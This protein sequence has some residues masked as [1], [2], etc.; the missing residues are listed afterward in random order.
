MAEFRCRLAT[1]SGEVVER[2]FTA[3]DE[4]ELRRELERQEFLVLGMQRRSALISA[5]SD[6]FSRRRRKLN[7]NEFLYFNQEFAALVRAGLPIVESLGMLLERRKNL[8]FRSA[9]EDIRDR[10]RSGESLSEAFGAHEMFPPLYASTL[11]SGERSGEIATVLD[12]YV[13][14]MKIITGVRSK[15]RAALTYPAVLVALS[16]GLVAML[17]T[18]VLPKFE[19]LFRDFGAELPLITRSVL[20]LST[21][22]RDNWW[23]LLLSLVGAVVGLA[24]WRRTPAGRR[25]LER[26][27]YRMPFAGS[28]SS[29]FVV[30]RFARTLSTLIAG[31]IPLV[32]CLEIVSRAVGVGIFRDAI[33]GVALKIREGAA[34]W[35]AIEETRL[36]PDLLVEMVKVGESSGSLAEML[37]HVADFTDQEIERDLQ[38]MMSLIEPLLLIALAL[39]VG[40]LLLAIYYPLLIIYANTS[41]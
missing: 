34:L 23:L 19:G 13:S 33:S 2:D 27:M 8:A 37:E 9:L 17:L 24:V 5:A 1:P 11:A 28:I 3:G 26:A 36:F 16:L 39:I 29:K 12:R 18:Y 41:I 7:L 30:T 35:S 22:I 40:F 21:F 32:T 4:V 14:Y 31:G 15:V 25:M 6:L 10:I 38:I 20:G